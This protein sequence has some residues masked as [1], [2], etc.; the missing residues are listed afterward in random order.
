MDGAYGRRD[1][2]TMLMS[3]LSGWYQ[4]S[5]KQVGSRK[6]FIRLRDKK[7]RISYIKFMIP[8]FPYLM[9]LSY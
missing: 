6:K 1:T 7:V 5:T 4:S 2:A 8:N 9:M 3:A